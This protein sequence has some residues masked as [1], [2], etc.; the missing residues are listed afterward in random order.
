MSVT[1]LNSYFVG[2]DVKITAEDNNLTLNTRS[3]ETVQD[4]LETIRSNVLQLLDMVNVVNGGKTSALARQA[5][6][7]FFERNADIAL[8]AILSQDDITRTN[9]NN[10]FVENTRFYISNEIDA[11]VQDTFLRENTSALNRSCRGETIALNAS[12]YYTVPVIDRKSVV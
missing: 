12:P 11:S 8:I 4:K 9:G 2:E 3:S 7:F 10:L 6:Q 5:E 1:F